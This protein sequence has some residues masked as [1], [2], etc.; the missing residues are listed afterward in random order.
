MFTLPSTSK[1]FASLRWNR[2][3]VTHVLWV[4]LNSVTEFTLKRLLVTTAAG[5]DLLQRP[6][7]IP[8]TAEA[9]SLTSGIVP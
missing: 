7:K 5:T 3:K 4:S 9:I 6:S 2:S 1:S 8:I